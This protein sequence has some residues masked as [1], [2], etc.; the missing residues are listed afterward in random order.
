MACLSMT[1]KSATSCDGIRAPEN[2]VFGGVEIP[3]GN[4][5]FGDMLGHA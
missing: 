2:L 3:L 5:T 1:L 4:S